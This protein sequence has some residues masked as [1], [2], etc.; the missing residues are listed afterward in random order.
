MI[1]KLYL[2]LVTE[3]LRIPQGYDSDAGLQFDGVPVTAIAI[4]K[5]TK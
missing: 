5:F 4:Y 2:V 3:I 1:D